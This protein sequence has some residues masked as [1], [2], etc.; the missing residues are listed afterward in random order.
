MYEAPGE[1]DRLDPFGPVART[2]AMGRYTRI[3]SIAVLGSVAAIATFIGAHRASAVAVPRGGL[4]PDPV[5]VRYRYPVEPVRAGIDPRRDLDETIAILETRVAQPV[6]S[7]MEMAD[8][9]DLYVK[10]A[11][12]AGDPADYAKAE[13]MAKRSLEKLRYPSSAPLVLAKVA[14]A[15]HEFGTAITLA[16]EY[17]TH[18]KSPG[19][20]GVLASS[21]LALGELERASE[22]AEW[23]VGLKPDSAGYL[24]RALVFQAQGRDAEAAFDF[25]HAAQLEVAGDPDEAAR[26]RALWAR[27]L[28]RRGEWGGAEELLR[29]AVRIAPENALAIAQQ[30]ELAL[31]TGRAREAKALFERAFVASRQ[32]RYLID[33]AR[34][35]ELAG[36]RAGANSTRTQVERLVRTD[37]RENGLGH[38]LDLVETLLDRGA[39]ADVQEAI[40][41]AAAEVVAR[42]SAD[43]RFQQARALAAG[44]NRREAL[45]AVRAALAT[46]A[47][48]ARL[49]ELASRLERSTGNAPRAELYAAEAGRLDPGNAGWRGLG[50]VIP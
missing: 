40:M 28:L 19:A 41:L 6:P 18:A 23:A 24:M 46:G 3:F 45:A 5:A 10:R 30:G 4:A 8:L 7:P 31:R 39:P 25:A 36:D 48:D 29:E 26:L 2:A 43:T 14:S 1:S 17:L 12:V 16:R 9:A 22:A 42:P 11:Q 49:Y 37:L 21:H 34:A 15:R 47:R 50:L 33:E 32:V 13:A 38:R 35:Q 20:L 27:F 44:G